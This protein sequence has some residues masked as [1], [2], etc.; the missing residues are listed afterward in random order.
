MSLLLLTRLAPTKPCILREQEQGLRQSQG[1]HLVR[2][3]VWDALARC[4]Q[5]LGAVA[6]EADALAAGLKAC[7]AGADSKDK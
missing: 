6:A 3:E 7:R 2:V 1:H 5:K 4:H